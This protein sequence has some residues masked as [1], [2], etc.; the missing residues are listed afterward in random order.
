MDELKD[1]QRLAGLT[2]LNKGELQ[3]YTGPGSVHTEGSNIS[4]TAMEK[5]NYQQQHDIQPGSPDW[6]RLWF[7]LPK[8][9]GEKPW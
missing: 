4:K 9:T 8:M 3:E 6:F 5:S 1:L 7:S 2:E